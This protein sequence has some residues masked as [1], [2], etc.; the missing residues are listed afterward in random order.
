MTRY[1]D[2]LS[3]CPECEQYAIDH[4]QEVVSICE[5]PPY[6]FRETFYE[7]ARDYLERLHN[8]EHS[9]FGLFAME[10]VSW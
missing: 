10:S 2:T 3:R 8:N 7:N 6:R 9:T 1:V 5:P 4:W